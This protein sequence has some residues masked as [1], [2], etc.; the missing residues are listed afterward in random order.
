MYKLTITKSKYNIYLDLKVNYNGRQIDYFIISQVDIPKIK[1]IISSK[2]NAIFYLK[3]NELAFRM[4]SKTMLKE[5]I[6]LIVKNEGIG[7]QF[8]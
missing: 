6:E 5:K 3:H 1:Q 2:K 4:I 7:E 8:G